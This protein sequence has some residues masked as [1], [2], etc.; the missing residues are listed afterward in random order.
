MPASLLAP[1]GEGSHWAEL[2]LE[3]GPGEGQKHAAAAAPTR[4]MWRQGPW[5]GGCHSGK[6]P[7]SAVKKVLA[8]WI[9]TCALIDLCVCEC[10]CVRVSNNRLRGLSAGPLSLFSAPRGRRQP[11]PWW[12]AL[13]LGTPAGVGSVFGTM[14]TL[15]CAGGGGVGAP[16]SSHHLCNARRKAATGPQSCG[17]GRRG[18]ALPGITTTVRGER[19]DTGRGSGQLGRA[20]EG[21]ATRG[22]FLCPHPVHTDTLARREVGLTLPGGPNPGLWLTKEDTEQL[23]QPQ[24]PQLPHL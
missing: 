15:W 4:T 8:G 9:E 19:R 21:R 22:S 10:G 20:R 5:G 11:P 3:S 24:G 7:V 13:P 12:A 17:R 16:R 18:A 6:S 14:R 1:A 2:S 23:I